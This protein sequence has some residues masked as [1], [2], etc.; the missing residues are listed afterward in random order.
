LFSGV[1]MGENTLP[2]YPVEAGGDLIGLPRLINES[3]E[4]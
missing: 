3:M 4:W 2:S 1:E